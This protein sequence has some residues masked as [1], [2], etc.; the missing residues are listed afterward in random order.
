MKIILFAVAVAALG[1]GGKKSSDACGEAVGK[2]VDAM[3]AEGA[4]R[5]E[6]APA[7]IKTKLGEAGVK[8]KEVITKRCTEDKWSAEVIDCYSKVTN[9]QD[10]AACRAKLPADQGAKLRN[11]EIQVMTQ[12]MGPMPGGMRGPGG[13]G[14]GGPGGPGMGGPGGPGMGAPSQPSMSAAPAAPAGSAAPGS[15]AAP[16]GH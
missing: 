6:S 14:M 2:G 11:E 9:R 1:C 8:L 10:V 7:E 15:A 3:M 5:M 13:P 12:A 16:A 4:K